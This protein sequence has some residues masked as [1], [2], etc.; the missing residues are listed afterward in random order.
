MGS[1]YVNIYVSWGLLE[2]IF[3]FIHLYNQQQ[4]LLNILYIYT[5]V[6]RYKIFT[7]STEALHM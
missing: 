1:L 3:G 5:Q 6:N 4:L 2:T 7:R